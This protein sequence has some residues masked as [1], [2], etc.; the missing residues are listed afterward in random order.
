MNFWWWINKSCFGD[1]FSCL[2][3]SYNDLFE[4]LIASELCYVKEAK[5]NIITRT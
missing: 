2:C 1:G 4:K 5:H 3:V